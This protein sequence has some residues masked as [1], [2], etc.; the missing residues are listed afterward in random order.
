MFKKGRIGTGRARGGRCWYWAL[1][2]LSQKVEWAL[3]DGDRRL[4]GMIVPRSFEA[5][6]SGRGW[7]LAART[8]ESLTL[9]AGVLGGGP[10][11]HKLRDEKGFL[12]A[13]T[14]GRALLAILFIVRLADRHREQVVAFEGSL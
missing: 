4:E 9:V 12:L 14:R 6:E 11:L 8:S 5:R 7:V 2:C 3:V 10:E 13:E 1:G